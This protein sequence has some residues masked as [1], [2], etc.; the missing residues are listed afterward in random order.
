MSTS[1]SCKTNMFLHQNLPNLTPHSYLCLIWLYYPP[2]V[3]QPPVVDH[4]P[5]NLG[6]LDDCQPHPNHFCHL[7]KQD[8]VVHVCH[9]PTVVHLGRVLV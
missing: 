7:V 1:K 3:A 5:G 6:L 8:G 9:M 2:S 4:H